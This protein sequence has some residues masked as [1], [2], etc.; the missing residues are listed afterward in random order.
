MRE[1][2]TEEMMGRKE[3]I[4]SLGVDTEAWE[5]ARQKYETLKEVI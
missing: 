4:E 1:L 3:V 2:E 5:D